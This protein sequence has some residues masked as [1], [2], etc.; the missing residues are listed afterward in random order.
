MF[1]K[2]LL[3][4]I[5]TLDNKDEETTKKQQNINSFLTYYLN[6]NLALHKAK[7]KNK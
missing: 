4:Y 5:P 3:F 2:L 6:V 1:F 7:I